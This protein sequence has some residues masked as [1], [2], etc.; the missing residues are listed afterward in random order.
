MFLFILEAVSSVALKKEGFR[1]SYSPEYS[2]TLFIFILKISIPNSSP[3]LLYCRR[4]V[5]TN[6]FQ[7]LKL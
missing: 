7:K 4:F 3:N 1:Y 5:V 6:L 2:G